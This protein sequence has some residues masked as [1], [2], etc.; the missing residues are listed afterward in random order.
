M[1][2][3]SENEKPV[4]W[5]KAAFIF[6]GLAIGIQMLN[7]KLFEMNI[8]NY[9]WTTILCCIPMILWVFGFLCA[10]INLP[11]HDEAQK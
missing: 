5:G 11:I 4:N 10:F 1:K 9:F 8:I 6:G 2:S 3:K 7:Q